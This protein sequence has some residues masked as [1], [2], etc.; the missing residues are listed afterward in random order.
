[1]AIKTLFLEIFDQ[2][3]SIVKSV[4]D[5]RLSDVET[6]LFFQ[7]KH[8]KC[9]LLLAFISDCFGYVISVSINTPDMWQSKTLNY[10]RTW[11]KD[12]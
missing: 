7:Q 10:Q 8:E 9:K 5:Y 11:I 1:M 3:L 4:S 2:S 12:H 6:K